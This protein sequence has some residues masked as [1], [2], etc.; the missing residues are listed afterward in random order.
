MRLLQ[1]TSAGIRANN[2]MEPPGSATAAGMLL[3][4]PGN[5]SIYAPP[6]PDVFW[7]NAGL[8]DQTLSRLSPWKLIELLAD[9]SPDV[10]RALWDF[11][12]MCNPGW[13][14]QAVLADGETPAPQ[15]AQD[16]LDGILKT[17][18][19]LY[20]SVD[21]I[22]NR[23]FITV[24]L[25]GAFFAEIV[26]APD[27][28]T[29]ADFATPDPV[30]VRFK[31]Q[32][33]PIR[34]VYWQLGQFSN[35]GQFDA[36]DRETIRYI[37]LDPF[38]GPPFGRSPASPALFSSIFSLMLLHDLRR[39][40]A[41]QG[42]PRL[43]IEVLLDEVIK[44]MPD[45]LAD[46]P[47]AFVEWTGKLIAQVKDAYSALQ[48]DDTYIHTSAVKL[49]RP[50]GAVDSSSLGAVDGIIR[51]VERMTIRGLKTMPLLMGVNEGV[52]ETHARYQWEIYTSAI[53]SIQH[54]CESIVEELLGF[55]L[56]AQGVQAQVQF[57]FDQLRVAE[58]LVD[59]QVLQ[60]KITNNTAMYNQGWV[61]Q[62]EAA[63]N[64]VGHAPAQEKPLAEQQAE[65]AQALAEKQAAAQAENAGQAP[66]AARMAQL[67]HELQENRRFLASL[68]EIV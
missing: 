23:M 54:L 36:L 47:A 33:D 37:P 63:Q 58:D 15:K 16:A 8:D 9:V 13:K 53:S 38:P 42:Y 28:R 45:D 65:A 2:V 19:T 52:S 12:R 27:G 20:G 11:L 24:Y 29:V 1:G 59:E 60:L 62:D 35:T 14:A 41:Q 30:I 10:S 67:I 5:G 22:I 26:F 50:I 40:V 57:R 17:F 32:T 68:L 66:N 4:Y 64:V 21:T 31:E 43:D 44:M 6:Q 55:A 3:Q 49:N 51:A 46:D 34:G 39:V 48:P 7:R 56:R 61:D 18:K 25:R